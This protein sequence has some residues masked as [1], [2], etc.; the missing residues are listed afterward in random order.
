MDTAKLFLQALRDEGINKLTYDCFSSSYIAEGSERSLLSPALLLLMME[1]DSID[2]W[3][4]ALVERKILV[5]TLA[6]PHVAY[7]YE[8]VEGNDG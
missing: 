6:K 8:I 5:R 2:R 1:V 7:V 4:I 3:V